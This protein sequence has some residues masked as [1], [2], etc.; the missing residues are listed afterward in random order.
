[1]QLFVP[2]LEESSGA[3][4]LESFAPAT[5][6]CAARTCAV[7]LLLKKKGARTQKLLRE[8]TEVLLTMPDKSTSLTSLGRML[9]RCTLR[10]LRR[11]HVT[12]AGVLRA[13]DK[14]FVVDMTESLPYVVYLHCSVLGTFEPTEVTDSRD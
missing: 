12:L 5:A 7:G 1:M 2:S 11:H 6:R 9:Q 3:S 14:D 13:F 4:A 10:W 8:A